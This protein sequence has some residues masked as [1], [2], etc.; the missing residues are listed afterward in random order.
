MP[1]S[2]RSG[3]LPGLNFSRCLLYSKPSDIQQ[4]DNLYCF[5]YAPCDVSGATEPGL[6]EAGLFRRP[7]I[8]FRASL[9]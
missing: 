2:P 8:D 5:G 7:K 6:T 4:Y 9:L 3:G 1:T